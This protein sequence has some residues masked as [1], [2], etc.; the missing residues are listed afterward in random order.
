MLLLLFVS[1][2]PEASSADA[3]SSP[4]T[5][6][7]VSV[8]LGAVAPLSALGPVA[9]SA[10]ATTRPNCDTIPIPESPPKVGDMIQGGYWANVQGDAWTYQ[11]TSVTREKSMLWNQYGYES[12]AMGVW[13]IVRVRLMN[14]GTGS[15]QPY[16]QDFHL[17][18][19]NRT[20]Y[21]IDRFVSFLYSDYNELSS[22]TTT[23]PPGVWAELGLVTDVSPD[24]HDLM[25]CI[26]QAGTVVDLG[27]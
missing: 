6:R 7:P 25:L 27:D 15:S 26:L 10:T 8:M 18:G 12:T 16:S 19:R 2:G 13:S 5:A 17:M 20:A 11:V 3:A 14:V 9:A 24:D 22:F 23:V 21:R 1:V 4:D